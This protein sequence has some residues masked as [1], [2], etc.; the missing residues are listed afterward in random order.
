[1]KYKVLTLGCKV[2][3]YETKALET[4]LDSRGFSAAEGGETAD[5]VIVNTCAVTAESGRKS[6]QAIRKLAGENPGALVAVCGCFS[7]LSPAEVASLGADIVHGSGNKER[8]ADD[9]EKALSEKNIIEWTDDPFARRIMEELPSGAVDGRTRA[10][11]KIQDGCANFCTYCI[12]PYTRGRVR[13]LPPERCALQTEE[14]AEKGFL[15]LVITG[16]EI[17]SYGRDLEPRRTLADAVE[18]IAS[19]AGAMRLR[20]GS[21][22]PT[23]ITED[24]VQRLKATGRVCDHFHLSLQSGCDEVLKRMNRKYDTA[25]FFEATELLREYFPG[26]GI[27]ADLIA[28]FPG[29]TEENHS[30]TLSFIRKCGFS[31]IHVFPYSKR[32]GTKA[33]DMDGQLTNSVKARR[34]SEVQQ[35]AHEME[36]EYLESLVG[37]TLSVLFETEKDGVSTGHAENYTQVCVH[38]GHLH[39]IVKNVE[40]TGVLDKMLV[41]KIV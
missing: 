12:I 41:G 22:E 8:L 10:M 34:A 18:A 20:L 6:R 37:A 17:A 15:E 26:C 21:L 24:F 11:L 13:S 27:T 3:Q 31:A 5:V 4:M 33:A 35:A 29:E 28:G 40:I 25:R 30:D 39:G 2:N 16:I 7:Q 38:N 36:N 1:M 9:I 32:P 23:V 14:L 19:A